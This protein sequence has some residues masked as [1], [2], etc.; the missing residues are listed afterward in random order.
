MRTVALRFADKIAPEE[1]T[2]KA[3]EAIIEANGFVWYGK[4]G[5]P[6]SQKAI[7]YIKENDNPKILLIHSGKAARYW[8]YV[9][10]VIRSCPEIDGIPHYYRDI[11]DKFKTWFKVTRIEEAPRDIMGNCRVI[12]SGA[13]LGEVSKHSMSPYF[14]IECE[15]EA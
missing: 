12:S 14:I 1:G 5:L 11:R 8:A 13:P 10:D 3:H 4:L 6:L 9:S 2:I 15:G 7:S